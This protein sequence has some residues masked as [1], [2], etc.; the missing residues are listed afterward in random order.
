[1]FRRQTRTADASNSRNRNRAPLS[2]LFLPPGCGGPVVRTID[3]CPMP[4]IRQAHRVLPPTLLKSSLS[5]GFQS[6]LAFTLFARPA[7]AITFLTMGTREQEFAIPCV[8]RRTRFRSP[9]FRDEP[10]NVSHGRSLPCTTKRRA[11]TIG[12]QYRLGDPGGQRQWRR[13]GVSLATHADFNNDLHYSQ[14]DAEI[15]RTPADGSRK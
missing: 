15:R 10:K 13:D 7:V 9:Y 14:L 12:D 4:Q 2:I 8:N 3:H 11:Q 1:M 6:R 5:P